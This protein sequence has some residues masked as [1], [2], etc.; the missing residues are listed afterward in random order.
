[1]ISTPTPIKTPP[2]RFDHSAIN[3]SASQIRHDGAR[4]SL[5]RSAIKTGNKTSENS[6]TR[7]IVKLASA[8]N[9]ANSTAA[10]A[11]CA[12]APAARA[13][14]ISTIT[15]TASAT[16]CASIRPRSPSADSIHPNISSASTT[17]LCQCAVGAAANGTPVGIAPLRVIT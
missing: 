12:E 11:P 14:R 7:A 13:S 9:A 15:A 3:G 2:W 4:A 8:P 5:R 16:T 6:C 1:M 17:A 10:P